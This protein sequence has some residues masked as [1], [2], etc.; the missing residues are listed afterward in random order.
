MKPV[1][2]NLRQVS[3]F[4]KVFAEVWLKECSRNYEMPK[5]EQRSLP[6]TCPLFHL[7]LVWHVSCRKVNLD[8]RF[9]LIFVYV[10]FV[11]TDI[12]IF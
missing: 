4:E 2:A 3:E 9:N 8:I 7:L 1:L 5:N 11:E 10:Y 6:D 12:D